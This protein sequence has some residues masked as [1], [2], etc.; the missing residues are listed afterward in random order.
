MD[1]GRQSFKSGSA[2]HESASAFCLHQLYTAILNGEITANVL[3]LQ[4]FVSFINVPAMIYAYVTH[5]SRILQEQQSFVSTALFLNT[6]P[7]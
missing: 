3:C 7:L 6:S 2:V 1:V 4:T 5:N